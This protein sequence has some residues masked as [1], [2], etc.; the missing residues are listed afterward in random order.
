MTAILNGFLECR[1]VDDDDDDDNFDHDDDDDNDNGNDNDND[2]RFHSV[3]ILGADKVVEESITVD[4]K[5]LL[6]LLVLRGVQQV[7]HGDRDRNVCTNAC[8]DKMCKAR[9]R[10]NVMRRRRSVQ[11][12]RHN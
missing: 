8:E 9:T 3:E 10:H 6:V 5:I 1:F 12:W 7:L 2:A 4:G 11:V